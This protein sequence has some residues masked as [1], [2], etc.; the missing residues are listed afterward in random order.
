MNK[1]QLQEYNNKQRKREID[2]LL[3]SD[4]NLDERIEGLR[5]IKDIIN[6]RMSMATFYRRHRPHIEYILFQDI[7]AWRTNRPKYFTYL[8]LIYHYLLST[9]KI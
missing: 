4:G 8:R 9:I 5:A 2:F 1:E 3:K 7:D 6:P